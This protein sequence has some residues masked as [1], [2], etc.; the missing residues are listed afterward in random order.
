MLHMAQRE[1][2]YAGNLLNGLLRTHNLLYYM[3]I[4]RRQHN[5]RVRC[6]LKRNYESSMFMGCKIIVLI[7]VMKMH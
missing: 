7:R 6:P 3:F 2:K 4:R 1:K 5:M